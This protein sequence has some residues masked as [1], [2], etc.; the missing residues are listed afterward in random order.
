[1]LRQASTVI[2]GL[3]KENK[4]KV[5]AGYYDTASGSVTLLE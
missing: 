5:I 3:V 1:L 4:L 2:S